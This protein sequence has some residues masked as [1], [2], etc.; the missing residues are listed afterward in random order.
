MNPDENKLENFQIKNSRKVIL[1]V[2]TQI[3]PGIFPQ[4]HK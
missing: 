2:A 4:K 3:K 1:N